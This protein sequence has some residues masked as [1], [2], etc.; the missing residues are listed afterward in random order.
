MATLLKSAPSGVGCTERIA[1]LVGIVGLYVVCLLFISIAF[2]RFRKA[3]K[4]HVT[5]RESL[6]QSY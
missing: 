5:V 6:S 4:Y 2:V 1:G 3:E